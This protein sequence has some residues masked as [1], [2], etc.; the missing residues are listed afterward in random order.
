MQSEK[1]RGLLNLLR[2][3]DMNGKPVAFRFPHGERTH[4]SLC[5]SCLSLIVFALSLA[6]L[7]Q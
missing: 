5:G 6:F 1:R 4:R 2:S 7:L 3:C